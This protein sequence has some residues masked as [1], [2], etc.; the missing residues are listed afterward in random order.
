[1]QCTIRHKKDSH[2]VNCTRDAQLEWAPFPRRHIAQT[3]SEDDCL[4]LNVWQPLLEEKDGGSAEC[5]VC[6][7]PPLLPA[8]VVLHG[9]RFQ[10]GG[11]GGPYTFYD[12]QVTLLGHEAGAASVGYHLLSN[13]S[14]AYF[15]RAVMM[16]GSPYAPYPD[17]SGNAAERNVRALARELRC[18]DSSAGRAAVDCLRS[19]SVRATLEAAD[20]AGIEFGPSYLSPQTAITHEHQLVEN[21]VVPE[22][23]P[24]MRARFRPLDFI[25]GYTSNEGAPYVL[26]MLRRSRLHFGD[27]TSGQ[28]VLGPLADWLRRHGVPEPREVLDFYGLNAQQFAAARGVHVLAALD[29]L[30]GDMHVYCPV[31]FMVEEAAALGS[32]V[33]TYEFAHLPYYRWWTRWKGVPQLLDLI[34]ASGLV[35]AI[36]DE[37]GLD[38]RELRFSQYIADMFAGFVWN[39]EPPPETNWTRWE[40]FHRGPLVFVGSENSSYAKAASMPHETNCA[41]WRMFLHPPVTSAATTMRP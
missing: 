24:N 1:M 9:G 23:P 22:K 39:G 34:Y 38:H 8:V 28:D 41:F 3:N 33:F 18:P 10:Y 36:Q 37:Y 16:A 29:E 40:T 25:A 7:H 13:R 35:R 26:E 27:E 30:L 32:R 11:G 4:Y 19:R 17:N 21:A 15:Q 20:G 2:A 31:N 14:A 12:W 5:G 6:G